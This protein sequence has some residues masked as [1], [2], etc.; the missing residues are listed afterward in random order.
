LDI[1]L[2]VQNCSLRL[3]QNKREA[4]ASLFVKSISQLQSMMPIS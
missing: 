4:I 2:T 1:V 3:C